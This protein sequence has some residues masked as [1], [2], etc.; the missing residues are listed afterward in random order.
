MSRLILLG[1][2]LYGSFSHPA[3]AVA[4][5]QE[6]IA[7]GKKALESRAFNPGSWTIE[8][9]ENAW[10]HWQPKLEKAPANYDHGRS[11]GGHRSATTS[12]RIS[13]GRLSN[14][15]KHCSRTTIRIWR[16]QFSPDFA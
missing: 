16:G 12:T 9:Y 4:H 1:L 10:R 2:C 8:A 7:R 13:A 11:N 3:I 15:S 14:T 6:A 5:D